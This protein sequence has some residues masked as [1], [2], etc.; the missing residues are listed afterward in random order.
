MSYADTTPPRQTRAG[1]TKPDPFTAD[2]H[3]KYHRLAARVTIGTMPPDGDVCEYITGVSR[4]SKWMRYELVMPEEQ[5]EPEAF[6]VEL[7]SQLADAGTVAAGMTT[8]AV[9]RESGRE[10]V[11][12]LASDHGGAVDAWA[13]DI[14]REDGVAPGLTKWERVN[15]GG[16]FMFMLH[17]GVANMD[18][19]LEHVALHGLPP[20]FAAQLPLT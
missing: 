2:F 15:A 18:G 5:P 12:V 8:T 20:A 16:A 14:V 1:H 19:I 17:A 11:F 3:A 10:S 7:G 13:A 9:S 6:S 4:A